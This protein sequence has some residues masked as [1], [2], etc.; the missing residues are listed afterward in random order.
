MDRPYTGH[1]GKQAPGTCERSNDGPAGVVPHSFTQ[2]T[3]SGS[4]PDVKEQMNT[5]ETL[6][7]HSIMVVPHPFTQVAGFWLAARG[8]ARCID[9][10]QHHQMLSASAK[11]TGTQIGAVDIRKDL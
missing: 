8:K 1:P 10:I 9:F 6:G 4:Q 2:V 3:G 11:H 7:D 5:G